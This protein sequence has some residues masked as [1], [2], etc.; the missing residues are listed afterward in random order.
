MRNHQIPGKPRPR[1]FSRD[2]PI[3]SGKS[4]GDEVDSQVLPSPNS[5]PPVQNVRDWRETLQEMRKKRL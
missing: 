3:F 1:G 5:S 4:P 2:P